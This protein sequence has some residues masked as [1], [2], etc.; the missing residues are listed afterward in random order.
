[1][2]PMTFLSFFFSSRAVVWSLIAVALGLTILPKIGIQMDWLFS[3]EYWRSFFS[4]FKFNK[5]AL[6]IAIFL[7]VIY[8]LLPDCNVVFLSACPLN[9]RLI[10]FAFAFLALGIRH[11]ALERHLWVLLATVLLGNIIFQAFIFL[12][13]APAQASFLTKLETIAGML[14]ENATVFVVP[15][16]WTT[17]SDFNTLPFGS[18]Y[19]A[20]LLTY[21]PDMYVSGLFMAQNNLVIRSDFSYY[22]EMT[23]FGPFNPTSC[24]ASPPCE[25]GWVM[26]GVE[27]LRPN[28]NCSKAN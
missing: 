23:N 18:H 2:P 7:F 9:T 11:G 13:D 28:L 25:Y 17:S 14:P 22:D 26:D 27:R 21:R 24:Y 10:P 3:K 5:S 19:H 8:L 20:L 6:A 15:G 4:R 1:M 16:T 12:E